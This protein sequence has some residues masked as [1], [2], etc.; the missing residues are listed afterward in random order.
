MLRNVLATECPFP[1]ATP[2]SCTPLSFSLSHPYAPST[3]ASLRPSSLQPLR[4]LVPIITTRWSPRGTS[5]IAASAIL[6]DWSSAVVSLLSVD[7]YLD[8]KYTPFDFRSCR[9]TLISLGLRVSPHCLPPR[10]RPRQPAGLQTPP[11]AFPP[12]PSSQHALRFITTSPIWVVEPC[13]SHLVVWSRCRY[14]RS[15]NI[16]GQSLQR[17]GRWVSSLHKRVCGC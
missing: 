5:R 7:A 14:N 4:A 15:R 2:A 6:S 9:R 10:T 3:L 12:Y 11:R 16:L 17:C 8:K 1:P 13:Q